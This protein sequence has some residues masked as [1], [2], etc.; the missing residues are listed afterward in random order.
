[1]NLHK[2]HCQL[3]M[4]RLRKLNKN[5][6]IK[7]YIAG[8]YGGRTLRPHY[9]MLLFNANIETIQKAWHLGSVHYG[10]VTGAS[11]GYTLK[12][13]S[14]PAKIPLH[15]N[16]DRTPEFSLMSKGIG[17]NYLTEKMVRYHK[18]DLTNCYCKTVDGHKIPMPR[19][20][21]NKIYD[22]QEIDILNRN[23]R[24]KAFENDAKIYQENVAKYGE[25][26]Y[27]RMVKD[28]HLSLFKK[29]SNDAKKRTTI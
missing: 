20:Y 17:E 26:N 14:K 7:Y 22:E 4:K 10:E 25:I 12:Y 8:E 2:R 16:D 6:K 19:Y 23:L 3:F 1:M 15:K 13:M 9:H 21:K 11:I 24:E 28:K 27:L 29:M 18:A 5:A